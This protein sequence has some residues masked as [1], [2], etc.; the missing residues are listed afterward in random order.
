MQIW[1][2]ENK[3]ILGNVCWCFLHYFVGA[4]MESLTTYDTDEENMQ[5]IHTQEQ[6]PGFGINV[7]RSSMFF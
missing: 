2:Y 3:N 5:G 1:K 7:S 4:M 6:V